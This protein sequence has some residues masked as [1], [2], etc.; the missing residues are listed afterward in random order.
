MLIVADQIKFPPK[1][2]SLDRLP[3]RGINNG[4]FPAIGAAKLLLAEV[5]PPA[6]ERR[7]LEMDHLATLGGEGSSDHPYANLIE[8]QCH[9]FD[10]LE[11]LC[12]PIAAVSGEFS[13]ARTTMA[14]SLRFASGAVG[15]LVGSYD[16]SYAYPE[17]QRIEVSGTRGRFVIDDTVR[18]YR[19]HEAGKVW[20]AGY[21]NDRDRE[22]HRTFDLYIAAMLA[23]FGAGK[24]PPVPA[25]AGLRALRLAHA[26][27]GA[28]ETGRRVEIP[29]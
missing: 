15:S 20:E 28:F 17:T 9:G 11:H 3:N 29:A 4:N 21:F 13:D 2:G 5:G 22:F 7:L 10:M 23:A 1:D 24:A 16:T 19:F 25:R 12:G 14:L 18:R 26:A 8:T 6:V 27:I